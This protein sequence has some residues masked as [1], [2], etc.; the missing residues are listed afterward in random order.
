MTSQTLIGKSA[1]VT[2][3]ARRIGREIALELAAAG[4]DVTITYRNSRD[5]SRANPAAH[6]A[7]WAGTPSQLNATCDPSTPCA[8][9]SPASVNFHGHLDVLVNN[10]AIFESAP[11]DQLTLEQWDAVFETNAR[12]PFLVA[13]EALPHLRVFPWPHH[14]HR[15]ARRHCAPGPV[16]PTTAHPRPP[17][18]CSRRPWPKP[19][20]PEVARQLCR[21]WLDRTGRRQMRSRRP[22]IR[23]EDAD[24]AQ[25]H[26]KRCRRKP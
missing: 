15:I 2:G 24:A 9:P 3:G 18:T 10:A 5:R 11:L 26:R 1:L 20:A 25:R 19:F 12:G 17:C 6:P 7:V 22:A 16:T 23:C 14:Q 13:R 8:P 21:S 4:A